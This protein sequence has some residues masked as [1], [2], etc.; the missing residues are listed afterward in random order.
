MPK[1][2]IGLLLAQHPILF[3]KLI[4]QFHRE[5]HHPHYLFYQIVFRLDLDRV[6]F[7][8]LQIVQSLHSKY[9]TMCMQDNVTS[10]RTKEQFSYSRRLTNAYNDFIDLV[11]FSELNQI[12]SWAQTSN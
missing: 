10:V 2:D 9:G 3:I 4:A 8:P 7:D 6:D 1:L 12:L 11:F 5:I